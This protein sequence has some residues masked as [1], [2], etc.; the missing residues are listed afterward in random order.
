MTGA[1]TGVFA[2]YPLFIGF[3]LSRRKITEEIQK[4]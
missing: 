1:M 3:Y 2:I 4:W